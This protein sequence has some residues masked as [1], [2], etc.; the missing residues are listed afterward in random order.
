MPIPFAMNPMG[1]S[2]GP[3]WILRD[4]P[5]LAVNLLKI[6]YGK[7]LF[8]ACGGTNNAYGIITS[9]DAITWTPR[10]TNTA[11]SSMIGVDFA[12]NQFIAVGHAT[13]SPYFTSIQPYNIWT[14][15]D[16]ITWNARQSSVSPT[17]YVGYLGGIAYGNN[18]YVAVGAT[19]NNQGIAISTDAITWTRSE[20]PNIGNPI[21]DIAYAN[22]TFVIVSDYIETSPNGT[23]WTRRSSPL[24]PRVTYNRVR[25][26]NNQFI[27]LSREAG[28]VSNRI[29]TSPDGITWTGK[30][31]VDSQYYYD[32]SYGNGLY[33]LVGLTS[34]P[35]WSSPDLINWS[36]HSVTPTGTI[37]NLT[38][39]TYAQDKFVAV[40]SPSAGRVYTMDW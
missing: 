15:T 24:S 27:A 20:S 23:T 7:G 22:N 13:A 38:G 40:G 29:A 12:N 28:N 2:K 16:G 18:V 10:L 6:C 1:L 3:R 26:L 31:M 33:M 30:N 32:I 8:V 39:I 19:S 11:N 37:S 17:D 9:P 4:V 25:F 14:S 21:Y 36:R 35:T 34:V 5:S